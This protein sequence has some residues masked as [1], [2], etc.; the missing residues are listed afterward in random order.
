MRKAGNEGVV[1]NATGLK[2]RVSKTR[3]CVSSLVTINVIN[4]RYR[5]IAE[6]ETRLLL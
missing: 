1:V 4:E 2:S 6:V 5:L 3:C